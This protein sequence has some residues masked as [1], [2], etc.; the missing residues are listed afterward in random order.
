MTSFIK[1]RTQFRMPAVLVRLGSSRWGPYLTAPRSGVWERLLNPST[2]Q[3]SNSR[4]SVCGAD[5]QVQSREEPP[6]PP[7]EC[8]AAIGD[9]RVGN[10]EAIDDVGEELDSLLGVDVDDGSGLDPLLELIDRY[11]DVGEAPGC[12]SERTHHV[13]VPNCKGPCDGDCLQHLCQEVSLPSVELVPFTAP[14]NVLRVGNCRGPVETLSKSFPDKC[15]R[16]GMVTIGT[17]MYL[18]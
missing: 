16:P 6:G 2:G 10:A 15:S 13:E 12:L 4:S 5:S 3:P 17:G 11:E 8:S 7:E 1:T 9:D 18:L 14:H